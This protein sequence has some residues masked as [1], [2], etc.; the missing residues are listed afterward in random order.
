MSTVVC[1][2]FNCVDAK[3]DQITIDGAERVRSASCY[4][5]R[6]TLK[7]E[8]ESVQPLLQRAAPRVAAR[9]V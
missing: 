9:H 8:R 3:G 1:I 7:V 5:R 4:M 2:C 6:Q